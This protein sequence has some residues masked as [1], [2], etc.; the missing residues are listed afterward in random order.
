[1]K[2]ADICQIIENFA[3]LDKQEAYD[4]SGLQLGD[5]L[6]QVTGVLLCLDLSEAVLD[7]A[8]AQG[9]NMIV[10]HH[11]LLFHGLK[12]ITGRSMVERMV[13]KALQHNVAIYAGHTNVD[14]VR[15]GVSAKMCEKLGLQTQGFLAAKTEDV[16]LGMI[17]EL[18]SAMSEHDFLQL[19]KDA[20]RC[21][22][23]RHSALTGKS[24]KKVALCGGSGAEFIPLAL[25]VHA[26]A[27]LTA[28]LK[29]HDFTSGEAALLLIDAGHFETEQY[30]K[31][32][33]YRLLSENNATFAVRIS[34]TE[35]NPVCYF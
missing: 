27:Y 9:C 32:I 25:S 13:I 2:V 26:D 20:F 31:E 5:P 10:S 12:Q 29:Y 24:I 7:E 21:P 23:L 35:Q 18:P 17:G 33:F 11:P 16:G 14:S 6:M 28:D 3:A 19:V 30:T 1:M 4:N 8:L 22:C 34:Q 15:Q